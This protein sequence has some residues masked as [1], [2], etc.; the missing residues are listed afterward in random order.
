V[1]TG[2]NCDLKPLGSNFYPFWTLNRSQTLRGVRTPKGAC[3]WNFGNVLPG[4]TT[5]NFGKDA[6]FGKSD[7]A[8]FGGTNASK[9]L[10]NPAVTARCPSYKKPSQPATFNARRRPG[11]PHKPVRAPPGLPVSV[12]AGQAGQVPAEVVKALG[13]PCRSGWSGS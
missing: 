5:Q 10:A 12:R 11:R 3:V 6:Q 2:A 7:I 9:V 1:T 4:I 8:R 13:E